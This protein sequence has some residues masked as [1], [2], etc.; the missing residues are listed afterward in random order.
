MRTCDKCRAEKAEDQYDGT[1]ITCRDCAGG[2]PVLERLVDLLAK[3]GE[4]EAQPN[5]N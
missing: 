4:R 5:G 2:S 1:A 3:A